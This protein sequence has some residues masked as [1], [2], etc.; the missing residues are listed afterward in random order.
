M[1]VDGIGTQRIAD[2]SV[3][4]VQGN[5][6]GAA[7]GNVMNTLSVAS[8]KAV[9]PAGPTVTEWDSAGR[10]YAFTPYYAN[11]GNKMAYLETRSPSGV[12]SHMSLKQE[13]LDAYCSRK[14]ISVPNLQYS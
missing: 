5:G 6:G 1:P 8:G 14:G 9:T 2:I 12:V 11:T 3:N 4:N 7:L 10:S 13:Q